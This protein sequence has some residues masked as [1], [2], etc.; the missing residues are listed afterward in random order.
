MTIADEV[1]LVRKRPANFA[2]TGLLYPR[3]G[4][5][6]GLSISLLECDGDDGLEPATS[7]VTANP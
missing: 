3:K 5:T 6:L 2:I 4:A 7:A 1:K